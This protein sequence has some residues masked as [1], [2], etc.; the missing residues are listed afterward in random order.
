MYFPVD[1]SYITNP[2]A[3][4]LAIPLQPELTVL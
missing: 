1:G 2:N 4:C 3:K